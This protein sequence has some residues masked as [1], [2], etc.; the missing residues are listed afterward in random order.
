MIKFLNN[1]FV[2][3]RYFLKNQKILKLKIGK[4]FLNFKF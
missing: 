2:D 1:L 4:L 3:M